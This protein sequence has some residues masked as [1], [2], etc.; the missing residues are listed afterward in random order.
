MT[1]ERGKKEEKEEDKEEEEEERKWPRNRRVALIT[2]SSWVI[3]YVT[4]SNQRQI[5]SSVAG[6]TSETFSQQT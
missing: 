6:D 3:V 5:G 2:G 4:E 1:T